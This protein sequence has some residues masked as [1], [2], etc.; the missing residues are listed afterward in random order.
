MRT[1][2]RE[3]EAEAELGCL[4][5]VGIFLL[6]PLVVG[7]TYWL[8]RHGRQIA[9]AGAVSLGLVALYLARESIAGALRR[10]RGGKAIDPSAQPERLA[11]VA[12]GRATHTAGLVASAERHVTP[13]AHDPCAYYRVVVERT[14]GAVVLEV[15]SSDDLALTDGSGASV[16]VPLAGARWVSPRHLELVS[17]PSAPHE[18]LDAWLRERGV[19]R[20]GEV[21]ARVEWIEPHELVFVRGFVTSAGEDASDYRGAERARLEIRATPEHPVLLSLAPLGAS[22]SPS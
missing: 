3:A 14:D 8:S 6:L 4:G 10:A 16:L 7:V 15:R 22:A 2:Y 18:G 20:E 13:F 9:A 21:R 5:C 11:D 19:A 12:A 17:S 1:T